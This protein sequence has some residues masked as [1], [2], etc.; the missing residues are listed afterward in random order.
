MAEVN[1]INP[2]FLT[3]YES[4]VKLNWNTPFSTETTFDSSRKEVSTGQLISMRFMNIY[5][6]SKYKLLVLTCPFIVSGGA[7]GQNEKRC[8]K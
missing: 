2:L 3:H 7:H 6:L 8:T 4:W 1:I 5:E